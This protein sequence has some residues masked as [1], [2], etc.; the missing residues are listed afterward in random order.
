MELRNI[1]L[2]K[3]KPIGIESVYTITSDGRQI[4]IPG[5]V[6]KIR[7]MGRG[8]ELLCPCGCGT[9]LIL[10]AGKNNLRE[11]HFREKHSDSNRKCTY[12]D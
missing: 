12:V 10:V 11:Q 5:R 1:A 4:N 7:I 8:N 3:G 2:Y 6:E 9:N